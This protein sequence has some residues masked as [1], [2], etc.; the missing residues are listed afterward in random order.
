MNKFWL[1]EKIFLRYVSQQFCIKKLVV[2]LQRKSIIVSLKNKD[3]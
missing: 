1:I 2:S 3:L